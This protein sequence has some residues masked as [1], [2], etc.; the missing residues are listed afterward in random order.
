MARRDRV[1]IDPFTESMPDLGMAD[2]YAIQQHLVQHLLDDGETISGYKLGLTSL[3]MQELLGV[4]Q[5][6]FGP[7]FAS[8]ELIRAANGA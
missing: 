2:G 3:A 5:P 7:V 1:P 8:T 4:D 6:G